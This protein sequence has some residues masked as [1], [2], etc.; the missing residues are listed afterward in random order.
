METNTENIEKVVATKEV[1]E[2]KKAKTVKK[3]PAKTTAPKATPVAKTVAA[4]KTETAE[5]HSTPKPKKEQSTI[6][7]VIE[8]GNITRKI[9]TKAG[10]KILNSSIQTTKAI[11]GIYTKAGKKAVALG[12]ELITD[13]TKVVASNQKTVRDTSMQAFKE[14]VDTIKDSH[15]IE[16]PLKNIIKK[17]KKK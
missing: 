2:V 10:G 8:T 12:K 14:T 1:K 16:N 4:P 13:T 17:G 5:T 7:K 3:A 11:A 15:L 6:E 9:V